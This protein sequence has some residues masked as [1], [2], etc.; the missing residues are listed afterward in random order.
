MFLNGTDSQDDQKSMRTQMWLGFMH[1]IPPPALAF[2]NRGQFEQCDH[3][4]SYA[5]KKNGGVKKSEG[6]SKK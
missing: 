6:N 5:I 4:N 1:N 3:S 2:N